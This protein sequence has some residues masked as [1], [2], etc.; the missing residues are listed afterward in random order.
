MLPDMPKLNVISAR[1]MMK[2]LNLLGFELLRTKGSHNFFCNQKTCRTT[3]IPMYG[4]EDLSA[5]LLKEIL[6]DIE[7]TVDDYEKLRRKV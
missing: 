4:N 5:G 6:K 1:K 7:L 3:V 2:I